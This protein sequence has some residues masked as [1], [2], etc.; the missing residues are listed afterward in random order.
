MFRTSLGYGSAATAFVDRRVGDL[1]R[2]FLKRTVSPLALAVG[3]AAIATGAQA[4]GENVGANQTYVAP[5]GTT[6]LDYLNIDPAGTVQLGQNNVVIVDDDGQNETWGG[7]LLGYMDTS[8]LAKTGNGTV[9]LDGFNSSGGEVHIDNGTLVQNGGTNTIWYLSIG[10]NFIPS[11]NGHLEIDSGT[12][13]IMGGPTDGMG[14]PSPALQVGDFGGTG[15]VMQTGGTVNFD[16]ASLNIGNQGGT[17]TYTITG[18]TINFGDGGFIDVGRSAAG[19]PSSTGTFN[20]GG[21]AVVDVHDN[22]SE[23]VIGNRQSGVTNAVTSKVVQTGGTLIIRDGAQLFLSGNAG[24]SEYDLNGGTL[25]IG[26]SAL[27][28]VYTPS[29]GGGTYTF[30]LGGGTIQVIG[31]ALNTSVNATL[32]SGTT[33]TIDTDTFGATWSGTLGGS[34]NLEKTGS[35][36]LTLTA[37]DSYSGYNYVYGDTLALTGNGSIVNSSVD[38]ESSGTKF[39]ISGITAGGTSIKDL[40]GAYGST[41]EVG[42]KT[43]TFGTSADTTFNG[44]FGTGTGGIEKDGSGTFTFGGTAGYSG[45]TDIADGSLR[46]THSDAFTSTSSL[47]FGN[48]ANWDLTGAG[49]QHLAGTLDFGT[50]SQLDVTLGDNHDQII[51]TNTVDLTGADLSVHGGDGNFNISSPYLLISST[52]VT[53]N[54]TSVTDDLVFLNVSANYATPGDVYLDFTKSGATTFASVGT[55]PNEKSVGHALDQLPIGNTLFDQIATLTTPEALAAIDSLEGD[56][57]ASTKSALIEWGTYLSGAIEDRLNGALGGWAGGGADLAPAAAPGRPG[58]PGLWISGYGHTATLDDP[59]GNAANVRADNGGLIAGIDVGSDG[60]IAGIGGGYDQGSLSANAHTS[61]ADITGYSAVAYAAAKAGL[62]NLSGGGSYTW[63]G[64][65]STR[66][67]VLPM[68]QTLTASYNGRTAQAF[69]EVGLGLGWLE[70]FAGANYIGV[71]TDGFTES[72]GSGAIAASADSESVVFTTLGVRGKLAAANGFWVNGMAGWRHAFGDI[73]PVLDGTIQGQA[74]SVDGVPIAADAFVA[75]AGISAA[76][77]GHTT[78]GVSYVGQI[79][80]NAQDHG[81]KANATI[82]F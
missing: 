29:G 77:G 38:L 66:T 47:T 68:P 49:Q 36:T 55:T 43:L 18:G 11:A 41:V 7:N 56:I 6:T 76:L 72:G 53:G 24:T 65:D 54:F 64:I 28:P 40:W 81:V 46:T 8:A 31:S 79:G 57:H 48:G 30:N 69:G 17:G 3:I 67:V 33:S 45:A 22:G 27:Q 20:I 63:N 12:L 21:D 58:G 80:T 74:F 2:S 71:D 44:N 14:T 26:D 9:T 61:S 52:G 78:I 16:R 42:T 50:G 51:S 25:E 35:S 62:L 19:K 34:G 4:A 1:K 37:A 39:D 75:E 10:S 60:W 59:S 5:S 13:N 70:P 32:S 15:T 73:T 82:N 23:F